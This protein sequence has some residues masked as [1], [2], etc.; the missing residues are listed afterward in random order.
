MHP[1]PSYSCAVIDTQSCHVT[2]SLNLNPKPSQVSLEDLYNGTVKKLSMSRNLTCDGCRGAGTKSGRKYEC[3]TCRGTG[4][5]VQI[6]QIGPGMLQQVQGRCSACSGTGNTTP[7][8]DRCDACNGKQLKPD[9]KTFEVRGSSAAG[10][11]GACSVDNMQK[12]DVHAV[13]VV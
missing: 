7:A 12:H 4:V 10:S 11:L 9:K 2:L 6:R 5:Q 13:H 3:G 8:S 1:N